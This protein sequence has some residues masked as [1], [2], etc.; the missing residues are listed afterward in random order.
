MEL[1]EPPK[2]TVQPQSTWLWLSQII[3][4]VGLSDRLFPRGAHGSDLKGYSP[5]LLG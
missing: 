3:R 2:I 5:V 4:R 1:G